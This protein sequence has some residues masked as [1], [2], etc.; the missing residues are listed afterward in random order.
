MKNVSTI[1]CYVGALA[2]VLVVSLAGCGD[3]PD[4]AAAPAPLTVEESPPTGPAPEPP[5]PV[6]KAHMRREFDE[7]Q[8]LTSVEWVVQADDEAYVGVVAAA[9]EN[10]SDPV[11]EACMRVQI[12]KDE[13][14][15]FYIV[16]ESLGKPDWKPGDLGQIEKFNL[17]LTLKFK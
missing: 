5:I 14:M 4:E 11:I 2:A 6:G 12:S 13:P 8:N 15:T 1:N 17:P 9:Y 10:D 16:D 3:S 7:L